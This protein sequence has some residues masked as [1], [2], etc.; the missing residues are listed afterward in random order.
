[1]RAVKDDPWFWVLVATFLIGWFVPLPF[2]WLN[3]V[4]FWGAILGAI[5]YSVHVSRL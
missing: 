2:D 1:M 5:A 4:L 3:S